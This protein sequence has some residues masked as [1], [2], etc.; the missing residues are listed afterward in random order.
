MV[1]DQRALLVGEFLDSDLSG[2]IDQLL[3]VQKRADL[4]DEYGYSDRLLKSVLTG[5]RKVTL[6]N[7]DLVL[8]AIKAAKQA[9]SDM[10]ANGHDL[11]NELSRYIELSI[12]DIEAHKLAQDGK[13]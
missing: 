12:N 13:Y 7:Y 2:K 6:K 1:T 9:A 10:A 3:S 8:A 11:Y 5:D 4:A